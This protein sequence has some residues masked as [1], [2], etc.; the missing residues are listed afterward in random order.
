[1]DH[2][3]YLDHKAKELENLKLGTKTMIIRGATG[4]KLP[5]GRV[6]ASDVLFFI[7]NKGDGFIKA[8]GIVDTVFFSEKLS[9]EVSSQMVTDH[10]DELLLDSKLK[11]RFAGK[12]YLTLIK[13]KNFE[14]IT[15]FKIDKSN[16]S[17]MDDWLAVEDISNV[18]ID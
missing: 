9:P 1:M 8:K 13:V 16:Y 3:V 10:Q 14:I 7:E 2:V 12:R 6:N 18:M 11:K 5:Y 15:P 17:T 4:R